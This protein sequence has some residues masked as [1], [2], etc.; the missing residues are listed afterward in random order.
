MRHS[1]LTSDRG[2]ATNGV[3]YT[4]DIEPKGYLSEVCMDCLV[5]FSAHAP[6]CMVVAAGRF[7]SRSQPPFGSHE[8]HKSHQPLATCP[9]G[10]P[11]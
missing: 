9:G 1:G 5:A 2:C 3:A 4:C 6:A 10:N 8:A 7:P 11:A